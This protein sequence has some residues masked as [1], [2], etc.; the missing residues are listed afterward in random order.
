MLK[1]IQ[2]YSFLILFLEIHLQKKFIVLQALGSRSSN[3]WSDGPPL[4][5]HQLGQVQQFFLFFSGPFRFLNAWIQPLIPFLKNT[6][7]Y[8]NQSLNM[9]IQ[10]IYTLDRDFQ[11]LKKKGNSHPSITKAV[12]TIEYSLICL[13]FLNLSKITAIICLMPHQS[14]QLDDRLAIKI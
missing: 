11:C 2:P 6:I 5:W 14:I 9:N 10:L 7:L 13:T 4:C 3:D 1:F 8:I 12:F